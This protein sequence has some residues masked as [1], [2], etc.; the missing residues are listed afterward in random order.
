MTIIL[1]FGMIILNLIF[2]LFRIRSNL[3]LFFNIIVFSFI[4]SGNIREDISD[5]YRYKLQYLNQYSWFQEKGYSFFSYIAAKIGIPFNLYLL[6][7]FLIFIIALLFFCRKYQC[8]YSVFFLMF[9][10]FYFFFVMEVLRFFL[11]LSMLIIGSRF[12]I[13]GKKLAFIFFVLLATSFHLTFIIFFLLLVTTCEK[14]SNKFYYIYVSFFM[15]ISVITILNGMRVPFI[16]GVFNILSSSFLDSKNLSFYNGMITAKN[17][18]IY[19]TLYYF[20]N[21]LLLYISKKL[22]VFAKTEVNK[23]NIADISK[24]YMFCFR[25]NCLFSIVMPFSMMSPTYFRI[26]FVITLIIFILLSSIIGELYNSK[27]NN[28]KI[29][30]NNSA[31]INDSTINLFIIITAWSVVWWYVNPNSA[32]MIYALTQNMFY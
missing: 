9:S 25:S 28:G 5:L 11:A 24:L 20:F 22:I 15:L 26:I 27:F 14:F 29:Y 16:S 1:F 7:I 19:T 2:F 4:Y 17:S 10:L 6:I 12:L 21:F 8:N 31:V 3:V 32:T 18:W 13:D 30:I 23:K